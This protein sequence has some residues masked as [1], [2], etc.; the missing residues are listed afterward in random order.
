MQSGWRMPVR[1]RSPRLIT[2]TLIM[3]AD[4]IAKP[5]N[6]SLRLLRQSYGPTQLSISR[7]PIQGLAGIRADAGRN[8]SADTGIP[9]RNR[10]RP[11]RETKE[12][13]NGRS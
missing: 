8:G 4:N 10:A 6:R 9:W 12:Q 11:E 13:P 3:H 5:L 7:E 2:P 1:K